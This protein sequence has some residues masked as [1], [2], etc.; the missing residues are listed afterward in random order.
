MSSTTRD[1]S[2]DSGANRV[3]DRP[4]IWPTLFAPLPME[5]SDRALEAAGTNGVAIYAALHKLRFLAPREH[6]SSFYCSE[7]Q[8]AR[9]SG[10]SPRRLRDPL[11][12]LEGAGLVRI[13]RPVGAAR[14]SHEASKITLLPIVVTGNKVGDRRDKSSGSTKT[15]CPASS[16]PELTTKMS[17]I[18][19]SPLRGDDSSAPACG[20]PSGSPRGRDGSSNSTIQTQPW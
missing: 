1:A 18:R 10:L 5:E 15:S 7:A 13:N 16:G 12:A 3:H 6:R 11:R 8:I 17:V 9:H 14:L 4:G 20:L 19:E 2:D